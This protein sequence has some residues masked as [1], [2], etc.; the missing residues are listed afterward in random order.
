M[1]YKYLVSNLIIILCNQSFSAQVYNYWMPN[2]QLNKPAKEV[3]AYTYSV[4][5]N[6]SN[7]QFDQLL[8]KNEYSCEILPYFSQDSYT[9][10]TEGKKNNNAEIILRYEIKSNKVLKSQK[11]QN[12]TI[13]ANRKF[14]Y[15]QSGQLIKMI[16]KQ[17]FSNDEFVV[18]FENIVLDEGLQL[19]RGFRGDNVDRILDEEY[20]IDN[21]GCIQNRTTYFMGSKSNTWEYSYEYDS[22]NNWIRK[23]QYFNGE[24][25][26]VV[27]RVIIY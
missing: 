16:E 26:Q 2:A 3:I 19:V 1:T 27:L 7:I 5:M 25:N 24:L 4:H 21:M 14:Y 15:N 18:T 6:G 11:F 10:Y 17:S 20:V 23:E 13:N 22:Q 8:S 12:E 9:F